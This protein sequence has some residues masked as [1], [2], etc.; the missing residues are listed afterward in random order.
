MV[1]AAPVGSRYKS[2]KLSFKISQSVCS[3]GNG[4][5][6]ESR[7]TFAAQKLKFVNLK[8]EQWDIV[9]AEGLTLY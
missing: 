7:G 2:F 4:R 5:R 3:R 9:W 8:L 1:L 6:S